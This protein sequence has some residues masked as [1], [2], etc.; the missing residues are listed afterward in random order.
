MISCS[1]RIQEVSS[2]SMYVYL[3]LTDTNTDTS[4]KFVELYNKFSKSTNFGCKQGAERQIVVQPNFTV[5][6]V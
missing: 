4:M 3:H 2:P 5:I 6:I 1:R